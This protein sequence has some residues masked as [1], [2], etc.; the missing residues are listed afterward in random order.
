MSGCIV[1]VRFDPA[2]EEL[3]A[4]G[5]FLIIETELPDFATFCEL[6]D[7]NRLIGGAVLWTSRG[8]EPNEFV[9]TRRVPIAFRGEAV[10]RCQLPGHVYVEAAP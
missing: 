5:R 8:A 3:A 4:R 2:F 10:L 6:V 9:I 1:K 7:G